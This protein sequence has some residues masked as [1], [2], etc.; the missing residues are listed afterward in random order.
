MLLVHLYSTSLPF[1]LIRVPERTH[2]GYNSSAVVDLWFSAGDDDSPEVFS[3]QGLEEHCC[4]TAST[5]TNDKEKKNVW[6]MGIYSFSAC[7][8]LPCS[9]Q[10]ED[11][12][13]R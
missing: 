1:M 2:S 9:C 10:S 13:S 5:E 8:V 4:Y 11:D 3:G 12:S 7:Y 6:L